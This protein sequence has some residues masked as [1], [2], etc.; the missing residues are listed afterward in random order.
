LCLSTDATSS[1]PPV[2]CPDFSGDMPDDHPC[3][4]CCCC[5]CSLSSF[6]SLVFG[7]LLP[8]HSRWRMLPD[9][10][11]PEGESPVCLLR[12]RIKR[13]HSSPSM[14]A[15]PRGESACEPGLPCLDETARALA[16]QSPQHQW[17]RGLNTATKRRLFASLHL[18][19][20]FLTVRFVPKMAKIC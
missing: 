20:R 19:K 4:C 7:L 15:F 9:S 12:S 3:C 14:H 5:C 18:F 13:F 8:Q 6:P 16:S 10:T 17:L 1:P 2:A 11:T